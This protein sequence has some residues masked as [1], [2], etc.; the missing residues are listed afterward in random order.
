MLG[1]YI[2]GA[3]NVIA[4][5]TIT[6]GADWRFGWQNKRA[7]TIRAGAAYASGLALFAVLVGAGPAEPGPGLMIGLAAATAL[8]AGACGKVHWRNVIDARARIRIAR[9]QS[10]PSASRRTGMALE[11]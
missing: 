7:A 3:I 2:A 11:N 4:I 5:A 8:I 10:L 1:V 6:T 9:Q